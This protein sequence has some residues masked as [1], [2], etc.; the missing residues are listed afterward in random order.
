[1]AKSSGSGG[2]DVAVWFLLVV[3][4]VLMGGGVAIDWDNIGDYFEIPVEVPEME[5]VPVA[6]APIGGY[7]RDAFGKAWEDVDNNKCDTRNDILQRDLT[8]KTLDGDCIVLTGELNDPYTG[9]IIKFKRGQDTSSAVQIDHI[10]P[11]SYAW[12]YG[13]AG[14]WSA[15]KRKQFA[16]DPANLI[17]VDGPT[18]GRKSDKGP[19]EF[20]PPDDSYHCD[21]TKQ[22]IGVVHKYDIKVTQADW[23]KA[24]KVLAKC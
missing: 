13:D 9:K 16:N 23:D 14:S 19:S 24:N 12:K 7:D 3:A 1:M 4:L 15:D 17:A 21:Y 6:G 20:M 5:D 8:H 18:N 2:G 11:L 10:V 22:F